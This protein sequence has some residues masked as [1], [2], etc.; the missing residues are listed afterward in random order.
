MQFDRRL[1]DFGWL[2]IAASYHA[3]PHIYVKKLN[4]NYQIMLCFNENVCGK[5][6]ALKFQF[7]VNGRPLFRHLSSACSL[8]TSLDPETVLTATRPPYPIE[9]LLPIIATRFLK[10]L[11]PMDQHISSVQI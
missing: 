8:H 4:E 9:N 6:I 11:L 5:E 2:A 1:L 10:P 7:A 3:L